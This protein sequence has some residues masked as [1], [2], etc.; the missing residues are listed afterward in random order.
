[1]SRLERVNKGGRDKQWRDNEQEREK[2]KR[3][4]QNGKEVAGHEKDGQK[5]GRRDTDYREKLRVEPPAK[6][7][8]WTE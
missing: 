6:G 3:D 5:R 2:A 8:E 4:E 1:M 7:Q